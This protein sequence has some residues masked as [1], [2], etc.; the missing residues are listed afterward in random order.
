M[1]VII[2][3]S[4]HLKRRH[5]PLIQVA[6]DLS[7]FDITEVV[8]GRN[9]KRNIHG[10]V[11]EGTDLLGEEWAAEHNLPIDPYPADWG[12]YGPAA[13]PIRNGVMARESGAEGLIAIWDGKSTGTQNMI[14]QAEES[15][16]IVSIYLLN[17]PR[18]ITLTERAREKV[19]ELLDLNGM[20]EQGG[21][22][23]GVK[24]GGCSGLSYTLDLVE[25][26]EENDRHFDS[27]GVNIYC[28]PKPYLYLKG[29]EVDYLDAMTGGGFE[30]KNPNAKRSCGCGTS[31]TT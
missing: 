23:L 18:M 10:R 5:K 17:G 1:K 19:R 3:G 25:G 21:I 27:D 13:G 20:P 6:V 29:T 2:A 8:S 28:A 26:P 30:F 31:F 24:A 22:R 12:K 9:G 16:L 7:F 11:I 14:T 4:R 15:N